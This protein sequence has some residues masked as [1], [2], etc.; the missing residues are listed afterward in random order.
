MGNAASM[1]A[2]L[3]QP[4]KP[5]ARRTTHKLSKPRVGN[6]ASTTYSTPS[7]PLKSIN[8]LES[9]AVV[10]YLPTPAPQLGGRPT[11][12]YS[13]QSIQVSPISPVAPLPADGFYMSAPDELR[14][15]PIPKDRQY[16]R[17]SLFR[18]KSS[19]GDLAEKRKS[20]IAGVMTPKLGDRMSRA[21][22]MTYSTGESLYHTADMSVAYVISFYFSSSSLQGTIP[23]PLAS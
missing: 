15:P 16:K 4:S 7:A 22:S 6:Y 17:T 13:T 11:S 10:G 19:Q 12:Y 20:F 14:P 3:P 18:S 5:P 2:S 1:E 23:E 9:S 8:G 21:N